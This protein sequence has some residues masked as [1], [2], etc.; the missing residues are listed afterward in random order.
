MYS[1]GIQLPWL[2]NMFMRCI[3][4]ILC[5]IGLLFLNCCIRWANISKLFSSAQAAIAKYQRLGGI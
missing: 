1:S 2:N 3:H 4:V 5:S